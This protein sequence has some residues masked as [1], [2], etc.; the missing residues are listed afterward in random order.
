MKLLVMILSPHNSL[1]WIH[2]LVAT[3]NIS[4]NTLDN[5]LCDIAK[6]HKVITINFIKKVFVNKTFRKKPTKSRREGRPFSENKKSSHRNMQYLSYLL[7]K[8]LKNF[9]SW[10][11]KKTKMPNCIS[12][13][14]PTVAEPAVVLLHPFLTL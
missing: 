10:A 14:V 13:S 1:Q 8:C 4:K 2:I 6:K 11:S 3:Y 12:S 9:I 5:A 7:S